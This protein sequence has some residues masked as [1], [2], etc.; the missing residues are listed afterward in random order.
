M[1]KVKGSC[2]GFLNY[3]NS[4]AGGNNGFLVR[5]SYT[6]AVFSNEIFME[7]IEVFVAEN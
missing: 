6:G 2:L 5:Y 4:N 7:K 1:L 3:Q